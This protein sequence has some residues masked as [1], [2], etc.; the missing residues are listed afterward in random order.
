[1]EGCVVEELATE[2]SPRHLNI[3]FRRAETLRASS[4][5]IR[6][7]SSEKRV[8]LELLIPSNVP[9]RCFKAAAAT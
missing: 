4:R 6:V 9:A 3:P 1:M 5:M 7:I 2:K 8:D